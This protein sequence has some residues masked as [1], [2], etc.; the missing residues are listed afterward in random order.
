MIKQ[1]AHEM[2][3]FA[4]GFY[5][6]VNDYFLKRNCNSDNCVNDDDELWNELYHGVLGFC[7]DDSAVTS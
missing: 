1:N 3:K 5:L 4:A 6:G 7:A 2:A